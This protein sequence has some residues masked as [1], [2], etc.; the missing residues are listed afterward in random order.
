MREVFENT[1]DFETFTDTDH[2]LE[3]L[4]ED[5]LEGLPVDLGLLLLLLV[6]QQIDL[7]VGVGR[8]ANVHGGQVLRQE[9]EVKGDL[10]CLNP[11]H[12]TGPF[13]PPNPKLII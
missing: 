8:P 2:K 6:G 13:W 3:G 10:Q 5:G 7:H 11:F 9:L 1:R 4:V 12:P